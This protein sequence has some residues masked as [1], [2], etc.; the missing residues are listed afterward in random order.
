MRQPPPFGTG[1]DGRRP[2][3]KASVRSGIRTLHGVNLAEIRYLS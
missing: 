1:L 2:P 3:A